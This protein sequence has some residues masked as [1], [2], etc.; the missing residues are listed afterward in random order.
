MLAFFLLS[1][2]TDPVIYLKVGPAPLAPGPG[3]FGWVCSAFFAWRVARGGRVSRM[4][5]IIG[6]VLSCIAAVYMVA[7]RFT[8]A[9]VGVLAAGGLQLA[10]LLSPAVYQRTRPGGGTGWTGEPAGPL[11]QPRR[12][13]PRWLVP[14]LAVTAAVG[15]T[16]TAVA[17]AAV[18][19][20]VASYNARTVHLR[21]GQPSRATLAAGRYFTFA[22]CRDYFGCLPMD[23]RDLT[24]S[25]PRRVIVT[26]VAFSGSPDMRSEAGQQFQPTLAFTVPVREQVMISLVP[27]PAGPVPVFVAP[28]EQESRYL[29]HWIEVTVASA[30]LLL[31]ALATLAW[32][33]PWPAR[34]RSGNRSTVRYPEQN[35]QVA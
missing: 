25:G 19:G 1:L 31:A 12:P 20:R 7:L 3:A 34:V 24:V 17:G 23:P 11:P 35:S 33:L 27:S 28:S 8:P 5:L 32:T 22:G 14:A 9:A 2:V 6:A 15:L 18:V 13:G 16:G 10:V 21:P 26:S 30:L 29:I 4:L